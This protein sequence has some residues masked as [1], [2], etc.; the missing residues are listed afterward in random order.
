MLVTWT[1]FERVDRAC[2]ALAA[3][4]DGAGVRNRILGRDV[5]R[6]A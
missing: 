1:P 4:I 5:S 2:T 3:I 6:I